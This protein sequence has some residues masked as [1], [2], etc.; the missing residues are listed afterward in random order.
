MLE[1]KN[2][3]TQEEAE[4]AIRILLKAMGE[5][6]HRE[7]LQET[8]RRVIK[9]WME[10]TQGYSQNPADIMK[11]FEDGAQNSEMVVRKDIPFW[12]NCEHHLLPVFGKV[13]IAYIP[14]GKILGLSKLDRLVQIFAQRLQVQERLTTQI[15]DAIQEHLQPLGVA[16]YVQARHACV[17]SRG[18]KSADSTTVTSAIRGEFEEA[19]TR[20]EFMSIARG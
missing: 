5:D 19:A 16:V 15:A 6:I 4:D 11:V 10:V 20:A 14:N 1:L 17:E 8:P 18:V 13:T 2:G 7:G 12:S 9:A 3:V